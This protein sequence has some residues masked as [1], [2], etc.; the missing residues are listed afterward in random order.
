MAGPGKPKHLKPEVY[1]IYRLK[2]PADG[3]VFEVYARETDIGLVGY[4]AWRM[5]DRARDLEITWIRG[6]YVEGTEDKL[7]VDYQP[8]ISGSDGGG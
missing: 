3:D 8:S 4:Y 1:K 2:D 5:D 7:T 6:L